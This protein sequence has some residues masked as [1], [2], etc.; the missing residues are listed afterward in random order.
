MAFNVEHFQAKG[1][2]YGEYPSEAILLGDGA[3]GGAGSVELRTSNLR[4][5]QSR[6]R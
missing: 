6:Q 5:L 2:G 4:Y 1:F 3:P